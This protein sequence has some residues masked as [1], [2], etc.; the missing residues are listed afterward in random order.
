MVQ[1]YFQVS[2]MEY[3]L[4]VFFSTPFIIHASLSAPYVNCSTTMQ[5]LLDNSVSYGL[6]SVSAI[7][8]VRSSN[9][10]LSLDLKKKPV[11]AQQLSPSHK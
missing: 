4:P 9:E 3:G 8:S 6:L 5:H 1:D 7:T 2:L 11:E 10:V